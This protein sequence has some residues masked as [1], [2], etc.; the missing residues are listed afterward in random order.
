M[1]EESPK[2]PDPST[3][4]TSD[5]AP[6]R[7]LLIKGMRWSIIEGVFALL[8]SAFTQGSVLTGMALLVGAKE[9]Q[10]GIIFGIPQLANV[11]QIATPL[12][13]ERLKSRRT[14]VAFFAGTHRILFCLTALTIFLPE[15][16]RVQT[17]LSLLGFCFI[18]A[19]MS[20]IPWQ[21]WMGDL[22]PEEIRGRFF[23]RRNA[24]INLTYI[25]V[26]PF[27]GKILDLF[28][29]QTGFL[30]LYGFGLAFAI[31]NT[32]CFIKQYEP[33]FHPKPQKTKKLLRTYLLAVRNYPFVRMV[34]FFSIWTVAR[35]IA[36]SFYSVYMIK[37]LNIKFFHIKLFETTFFIVLI[38]ASLMWGYLSDRFG[39]RPIARICSA[40]YIISPILWIF[41][42]HDTYLLL[43]GIHILNG[44]LSAGMGIATFNLLLVSSPRRNKSVYLSLWA[45]ITGISGF[46][47][48]Y[49]GGQFLEIFEHHSMTIG[50]MN[51]D[52]YQLLFLLSS[53]IT[54][55]ACLAFP[56]Q[57]ESKRPVS[58]SFY[59]MF[60]HLNPVILFG[61]IYNLAVFNI[62][63]VEKSRVNASR[64]LGRI[65]SPLAVN[66]LIEAMDDPSPEVREEAALSLGQIGDPQAID[67]LIRKLQSPE[68]N[69]QEEA[70]TALGMLQSVKAVDP[71]LRQLN[72]PEP[73]LKISVVEALGNIKDE[74]AR[75]ALY[76]Q[77]IVETDPKIFPTM[78]S[79]LAKMQDAR[80]VNIALS[81]LDRFSSPVV[82]RQILSSLTYLLDDDDG[83]YEVSGLDS[84]EQDQWVSK[85]LKVMQKALSGR[86]SP[87]APAQKDLI[88]QII[89]HIQK[90]YEIEKYD[91]CVYHV[92]QL[93]TNLRQLIID[94]PDQD[95]DYN[96]IQLELD[97]IETLIQLNNSVNLE[98]DEVLFILIALDRAVE[99]VTD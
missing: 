1:T 67:I 6:P 94:K 29:G 24:I 81:K 49:C 44:L 25:V 64:A 76:K 14:Y 80:V 31:V 88:H 13:V 95:W 93:C 3:P 52:H 73:S 43:F 45:A 36:D 34:L 62:S 98:R 90:F 77:V 53:G 92:K 19:S 82:R 51:L 79:A 47:G 71:L 85:H 84:F 46:V 87:I 32:G 65:R 70:A 55:A 74:K 11:L 9:S 38:I 97:A 63:R 16:I 28:P 42:T 61:L 12:W 4:T 58:V 30:I 33:P 8:L 75:E 60:R 18:A 2:E 78:V 17:Y 86:H 99:E 56:N 57:T 22:V 54:L 21:T 83:F 72:A 37:Q 91:P 26:A 7:I 15:S 41:V 89:F 5:S 69:I 59:Q 23:A 40:L 50:F 27:A 39:N 68:E 10:L 96:L 66:E 35:A 48:S 20:S